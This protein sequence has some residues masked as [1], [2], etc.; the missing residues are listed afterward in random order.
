MSCSKIV[1]N[2]DKERFEVNADWLALIIKSIAEDEEF[3]NDN[4]W[5]V[6]WIISLGI[7]NILFEKVINAVISDKNG[8]KLDCGVIDMEV[9][10]DN[11]DKMT[12]EII[13]IDNIRVNG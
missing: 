10:C 12:K 1:N 4:I 5:L 2:N 7:D 9:V 11:N 6:L 3:V 13:D 8:M